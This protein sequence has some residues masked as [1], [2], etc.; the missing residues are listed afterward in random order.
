V[1]GFLYAKVCK[2]IVRWKDFYV[3]FLKMK[4]IISDEKISGGL[5]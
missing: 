3:D 4:S 1:G 2:K 5:L